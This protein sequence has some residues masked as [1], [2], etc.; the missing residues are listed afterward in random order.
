MCFDKHFEDKSRADEGRKSE[1]SYADVWC[2]T[3]DST[4]Q[5]SQTAMSV[6]SFFDWLSL[7]FCCSFK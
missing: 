6:N 1:G 5:T 3:Q 7:A 2:F 4:R